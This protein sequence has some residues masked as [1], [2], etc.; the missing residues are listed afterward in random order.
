MIAMNYK[1]FR[2]NIKRLGLNNVTYARLMGINKNRVGDYNALGVPKN[3]ALMLNHM[4]ARLD[5][6]ESIE[7]IIGTSERTLKD[8]REGDKV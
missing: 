1:E 4:I 8:F 7:A 5:N 6:G 3:V 2:E